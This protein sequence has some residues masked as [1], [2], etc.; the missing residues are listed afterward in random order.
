M[1]RCRAAGSAA[2]GRCDS[3]P[4]VAGAGGGTA[5][6]GAHCGHAPER[7][8]AAHSSWSRATQHFEARC[9]SQSLRSRTRA[10]FRACLHRRRRS[11]VPSRVLLV[12]RCRCWRWSRC[13]AVVWPRIQARR[14]R[15]VV[16]SNHPLRHCEDGDDAAPAGVDED[17]AVGGL[18]PFHRHSPQCRYRCAGEP[19]AARPVARSIFGAGGRH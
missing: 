4:A 16:V 3:E 5:G 13:A 11:R 1:G 18:H 2:G 19:G 17:L 10:E 6:H 15:V 12:P 7:A 14:E 8:V 9:D